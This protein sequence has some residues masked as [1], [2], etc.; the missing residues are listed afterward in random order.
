[1]PFDVGFVAD[2][3][4]LGSRFIHVLPLFPAI[5]Q[6]V[7]QILFLTAGRYQRR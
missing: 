6:S 4:A 2:E 1:M 7:L 5:M 3:V